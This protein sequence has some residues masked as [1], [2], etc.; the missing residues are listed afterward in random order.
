M[1]F[2]SMLDKVEANKPSCSSQ[3]VIH[4]PRRGWQA[5]KD[6]V[7]SSIVDERL[8][9]QE[10]RENF[11]DEES[12]DDSEIY[13]KGRKISKDSL[14]SSSSEEIKASMNACAQEFA[15]SKELRRNSQTNGKSFQRHIR[16]NVNNNENI[17]KQVIDKPNV[18]DVKTKFIDDQPLKASSR[19]EIETGKG[20]SFYSKVYKTSKYKTSNQRQRNCDNYQGSVSSSGSGFDNSKDDHDYVNLSF[21]KEEK[22]T[23]PRQK[24]VTFVDI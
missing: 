24:T 20:E 16:I 5:R 11:L 19:N 23:E 14:S 1:S 12:T 3:L 10:K 7:K 6:P 15:N 8:E 4:Q 13:I 21:N 2:H 22:S 18:K 17:K 9:I